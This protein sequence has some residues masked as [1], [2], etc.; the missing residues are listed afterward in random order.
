MTIHNTAISVWEFLRDQA[1]LDPKYYDADIVD[2]IRS[3]LH[4]AKTGKLG[5]LLKRSKVSTEDFL[6][7]FFEAVQPYAEMMADLLRMFEEAGAKTT[8]K[9]LAVSF[10]FS[11]DLPKLNFDLEHFRDWLSTLR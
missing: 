3:R 5:T 1:G 4:L 2:D 7:A 9:Q 10:D 11:R 6:I 8:N